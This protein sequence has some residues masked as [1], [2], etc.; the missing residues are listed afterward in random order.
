MLL[1]KLYDGLLHSFADKF[2]K[3]HHS[4]QHTE[5]ELTLIRNMQRRN[6]STGLIVLWIK[7]RQRRY[8][9]SIYGLYR[10]LICSG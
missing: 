6:P 3:P 4:N 8:I 10:V 5:E 1:I 9:R 2:H 7:L